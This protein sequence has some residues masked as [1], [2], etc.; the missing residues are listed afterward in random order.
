[1]E[2]KIEIVKKAFNELT[3]T[4]KKITLQQVKD[5]SG[6]DDPHEEIDFLIRKGIII[7]VKQDEFR[8]V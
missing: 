8:L 5:A 6:L 4:D 2:D 3:E 7:K 1:M